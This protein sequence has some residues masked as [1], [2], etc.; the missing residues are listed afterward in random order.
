[1]PLNT[2]KMWS[3]GI[4]IAFFSKKLR[5]ITQR[6]GTSPPDPY[7]LWQLG[8]PPQD[9]HLLYVWIT[10]HFFTE[11]TC[12]QFRHC[13]ILI[14]GFLS[15]LP[16]TSFY[17]RANTGPWLLIFHFT[18]SFP[19]QKILFRSFWS[20]HCMWFVVWAPPPI[21]NP[22]YAYVEVPP[23][24]EIY[25]Q[26]IILGFVTFFNFIDFISVIGFNCISLILW[27][28]LYSTRSLLWICF[29]FVV[30]VFFIFSILFWEQ[31]NKRQ[32]L[33]MHEPVH[34]GRKT[35]S[36]RAYV[37][38]ILPNLVWLPVSDPNLW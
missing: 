23:Q 34:A 1:M 26:W 14:I 22:G 24:I 37:L 32:K 18:I 10:V 2:C 7:C 30:L 17:L 11:H 5:K 16:W 6:L 27:L 4:K 3:N 20:R 35:A 21:K 33:D 38:F 28:W 12:S 25:I 9:P 13:R 29:S 15:I 8:A 31:I 36:M 19:P